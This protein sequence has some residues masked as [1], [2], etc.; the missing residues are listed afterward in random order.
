MLHDS[1]LDIALIVE[2]QTTMILKCSFDFQQ[3][4]A[5][6]WPMILLPMRPENYARP[7]SIEKQPEWKWLTLV[8]H[9]ACF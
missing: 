3:G 8:D 5:I 6:Q 9:I 1:D 7:Q 4:L 2:H